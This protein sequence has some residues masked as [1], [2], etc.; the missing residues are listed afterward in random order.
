MAKVKKAAAKIEARMQQRQHE[1]DKREGTKRPV[2]KDDDDDGDQS[3]RRDRG[4]GGA[5]APKAG[6]AGATCGDEEDDESGDEEEVARAAAAPRRRRSASPAPAE[7]RLGPEQAWS[8]RCL[9]RLDAA[10]QRQ[11]GMQTEVAFN[12][13]APSSRKTDVWPGAAV[14]RD[15][16]AAAQKSTAARFAS[17]PWSNG[18]LARRGLVLLRATIDAL[19]EGRATKTRGIDEQW[20]TEARNEL[21][22]MAPWLMGVSLYDDARWVTVQ[23]PAERGATC[24]EEKLAKRVIWVECALRL[25]LIAGVDTDEGWDSAMQLA[26]EDKPDADEDL[27]DPSQLAAVSNTTL[28]KAHRFYT[29]DS[30]TTQASAPAARAAE[31]RAGIWRR[32]YGMAEARKEGVF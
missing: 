9:F 30:D 6:G 2:R 29:G 1:K 32:W 14:L 5:I 16:A 19:D 31:T 18:E 10:E 25:M 4:G 12:E 22:A 11:L 26:L 28:S 21:M 3:A 8:E 24:S 27:S 7:G 23:Q 15:V 13:M 17:V 20:V